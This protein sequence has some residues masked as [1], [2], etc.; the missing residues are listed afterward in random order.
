[1]KNYVVLYRTPD[2][3]PL[4]PP[5]GFSCMAESTD[6]A[7]EQCE[8]AYPACDV[9][10]VW[11]GPEGVGVQPA[12]DDYYAGGSRREGMKSIEVADATGPAL[13]WLV[14]KIEGSWILS[15]DSFVPNHQLGRMNFS[16]NWSQGGPIIEREGIQTWK[17]D[18]SSDWLASA[19]GD[20]SMDRAG[21]PYASG[22]TLLI[23]AMRCYVASRIG[24][25]AEVPEDLE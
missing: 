11:V 16:T 23:A 17:D 10:W 21:A 6:H 18:C 7:E 1:V 5:M 2:C 3:K 8:N 14:A 19:F 22:P 9:V 20:T 13:D 12:L 24:D 15:L 25:T 4:D